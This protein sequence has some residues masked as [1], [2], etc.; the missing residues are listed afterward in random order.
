MPEIT[1]VTLPNGKR[2]WVGTQTEGKKRSRE[3][4][5]TWETFRVA[6]DKESLLT[7]IQTVE[8]EASETGAAPGEIEVMAIPPEPV[9]V[10]PPPPAPRPTP[11]PVD[12]RV[13]AI[14]D[15]LMEAKPEEA[16]RYVETTVTRLGELGVD[17]R[18]MLEARM[19]HLMLEF[20]G[21]GLSF[22]RGVAILNDIA[23]YTRPDKPGRMAKFGERRR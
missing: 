18:D 22:Y 14:D 12:L 11:P 6:T 21:C 13:D 7:F 2:E 15:A 23:A 19:S 10:P 8:A 4:G 16:I 9:A 1:R 3:V 17:G 20:Q 5:G